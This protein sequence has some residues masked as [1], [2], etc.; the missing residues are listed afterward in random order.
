MPGPSMPLRRRTL[1]IAGSPQGDDGAQD[2]GSGPNSHPAGS[3][4]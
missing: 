3:P 2:R 4:A 1:S